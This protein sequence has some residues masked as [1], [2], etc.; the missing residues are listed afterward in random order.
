MQ[1]A[2]CGEQI[3]DGQAHHFMADQGNVHRTCRKSFDRGLLA[4]AEVLRRH[5]QAP[6]GAPDLS[7]VEE[8]IRAALSEFF[9]GE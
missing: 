9:D 6:G 5:G 3:Q 2:L 4:A 1:C 7:V 8:E